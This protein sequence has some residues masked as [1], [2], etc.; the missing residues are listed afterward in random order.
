[1][2]VLVFPQ[3]RR[4]KKGKGQ[5]QKQSQKIFFTQRRR[6]TEKRKR[7]VKGKRFLSRRGA[8]ERKGKVKG[9]SKGKRS[10]SPRGAEKQ[11]KEE[12]R[13]KVKHSKSRRGEGETKHLFCLIIFSNRFKF[14]SVWGCFYINNSIIFSNRN[15]NIPYHCIK[16][17]SI[18]GSF[19]SFNTKNCVFVCFRHFNYSEEPMMAGF[20]SE[21]S[22]IIHESAKSL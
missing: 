21:V 5:S 9:K 8:G 12:E 14:T 3:G 16:M 1:M 18:G 6:D 2:C 10:F 22:K 7:R 20:L 19:Q 17:S 13:L 4:G 15:F 11:R